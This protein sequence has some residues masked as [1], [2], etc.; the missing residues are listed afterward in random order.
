M[1]KQGARKRTASS[2]DEAS[3]KASPTL[4]KIAGLLALIATK[5]MDKDSAALKLD[6]CGFTAREIAD[7]LDVGPNYINVARHR[8]NKK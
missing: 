2:D 6:A 7:L 8:K 3:E 5:E 4:D 1:A